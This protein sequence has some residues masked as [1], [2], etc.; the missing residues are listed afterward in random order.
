MAKPTGPDFGYTDDPAARTRAK[1]AATFKASAHME[2]LVEMQR[3]DPAT[4]NSLGI[5]TR[6]SLGHYLEAKRAYEEVNA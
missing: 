2:R 6:L 4:F 5:T 1:L 3:T